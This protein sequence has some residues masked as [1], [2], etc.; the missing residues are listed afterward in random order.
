MYIKGGV[1]F[2]Q[3]GCH[4]TWGSSH[5]SRTSAPGEALYPQAVPAK[6]KAFFPFLLQTGPSRPDP[7]PTLQSTRQSEVKECHP[8]IDESPPLRARVRNTPTQQERG[9]S[10]ATWSR[11]GSRSPRGRR[12]RA[13][14]SPAPRPNKQ[15]SVLLH[16]RQREAAV[17]APG[18]ARHDSI[19]ANKN[20][21]RPE[22]V[23]L[24]TLHCTAPQSQSHL[25]EW[26]DGRM[27][28]LPRVCTHTK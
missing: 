6:G 9:H 8:S 4:A 20:R 7:L 28:P 15:V 5:D 25:Q 17:L 21:S 12:T 24:V 14:G 2:C 13:A 1:C 27:L 26:A 23:L 3:P 11:T 10:P 18:V 16:V 22:A 19:Q